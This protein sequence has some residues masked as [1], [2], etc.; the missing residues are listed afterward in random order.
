MK[1]AAYDYKMIIYGTWK[2]EEPNT[3]SLSLLNGSRITPKVSSLGAET[4]IILKVYNNYEGA[5]FQVK[6]HLR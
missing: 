5:T 2:I 6:G 3:H 4:T 1:N